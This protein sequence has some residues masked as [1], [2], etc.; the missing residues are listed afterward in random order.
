M[1]SGISIKEGEGEGGGGGGQKNE[2][3]V[4]IMIHA[5]CHCFDT[6]CFDSYCFDTYCFI[7]NRST[8]KITS[9]KNDQLLFSSAYNNYVN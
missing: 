5:T 1:L 2:T 7:L 8:T 6:C 3:R 9:C 4:V